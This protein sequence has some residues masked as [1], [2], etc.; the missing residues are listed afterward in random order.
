MAKQTAKDMHTAT[1]IHIDNETETPSPGV[2]GKVVGNIGDRGGDRGGEGGGESGGVIGEGG[3]E[4]G[5]GADGGDG[6]GKFGHGNGACGDGGGGK[7]GRGE[8]GG[9][10][11][12]GDGGGAEG[13]G[14]D[15]GGGEG[16]GGTGGGEGAAKITNVVVGGATAVTPN[17]LPLGK[18]AAPRSPVEALT[19]L[20]LAVLAA[21]TLG[22]MTDAVTTKAARRRRT[23]PKGPS[24]SPSRGGLA[25]CSC[26]RD[27]A[28][29]VS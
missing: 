9:E 21:A 14:G 8:R 7:G 23:A 1:T 16:G 6:G 22:M 12:R 27:P 25:L 29:T 5:G 2:I 28:E 20:V 15:N 11:G 18:R 24:A 17:E 3:G 10:G 26:R 13:S 19:M 4:G